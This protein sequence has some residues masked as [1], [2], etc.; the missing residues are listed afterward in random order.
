MP[1]RVIRGEFNASESMAARSL[2][3]ELLFLKLILA[4]DDYGRTDARPRVLRGRVFPLRDDV[5][6]VDVQT[7]LEELATGD[8]PP[9]VVYEV[10]EKPYLQLVNWEKHRG[11]SRRGHKSR[12]PAP[13]GVEDADTSGVVYFVMSGDERIKIGYSEVLEAR[14][15]TLSTMVPDFKLLGTIDS[16]TR[17]LEKKLHRKFAESRKNGEWFEASPEILSYIKENAD[18]P[19]AQ[20]DAAGHDGT[21]RDNAAGP[22]GVSGCRGSE[23]SGCTDPTTT[24]DQRP[25]DPP[26]KDPHRLSADTP[27]LTVKQTDKLIAMKPH[28][29]VFEPYEVACWFAHKH[30]AM[31]AAGKKDFWATARNWWRGMRPGEVHDAKKWVRSVNA[32]A[33]AKRMADE[34]KQPAMEFNAQEL[35]ELADALT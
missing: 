34:P 2:Y 17:A 5:N 15:N 24:S 9:V 21:S 22:P 8:D 32:Q 16:P 26:R 19:V 3:A 12:W 18:C 30:P 35:K 25:A 23:V 31:V 33:T 14:L 10:D 1:S 29:V 6:V 7:W 20:Q 28:G 11:N 13:P 4:V 27:R